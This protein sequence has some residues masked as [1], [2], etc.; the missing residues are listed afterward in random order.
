MQGCSPRDPG[1][2]SVRCWHTIPTADCNRLRT[3][4]GRCA[5]AA[6][7]PASPCRR[8]STPASQAS[9]GAELHE[10]RRRRSAVAGLGS[11]ALGRLLHRRVPLRS[12]ARAPGGPV[13]QLSRSP[14]SA[15]VSPGPS[16]A[17]SATPKRSPSASA[18]P[19]MNASRAAGNRRRAVRR[20][21]HARP[22]CRQ[23][24]A[25]RD[26]VKRGHPIRCRRSDFPAHGRWISYG[27]IDSAHGTGDR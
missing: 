14:A 19:A 15:S 2:R 7:P 3:A 17:A 5:D 22:S 26:A 20:C 9:P 18:V 10:H 23:R 13:W 11:P 12:S 24:G 4:D 25:T 8:R 1:G 27:R 6:R 16:Q 21:G